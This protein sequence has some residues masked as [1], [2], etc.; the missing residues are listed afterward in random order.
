MWRCERMQIDT[1]AHRA[2]GIE[3]DSGMRLEIV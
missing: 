2:A 1:G 3:S